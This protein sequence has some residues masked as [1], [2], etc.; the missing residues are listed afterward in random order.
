MISV[1]DM[2]NCCR[3]IELLHNGVDITQLD[4]LKQY[5]NPKTKKLQSRISEH[6][7]N[8]FIIK[9]EPAVCEFLDWVIGE[10]LIRD[11]TSFKSCFE[12]GLLSDESYINIV[13]D[14]KTFKEVMTILKRKNLTTFADIPQKDYDDEY[15]KMIE[16]QRK[17]FDY[18]NVDDA[19]PMIEALSNVNI[20]QNLEVLLALSKYPD[21]LGN[22]ILQAFDTVETDFEIKDFNKYKIIDK[23]LYIKI[24]QFVKDDITDKHYMKDFNYLV[25]SRNPYDYYFCSWGSSIQSCFSLNSTC[26]GWHGIVPMSTAK[27]SF[28][29]YGTSGV[30]NKISI[31]N[32]TKWPCPRILFR[33][34]GWLKPD[35][36]LL[37]DK[38]YIGIEFN[39][40]SSDVIDKLKQYVTNLFGYNYK[41][42]LNK[43]AYLLK[44]GEEYY[45]IQKEYNCNWYPD[46]VR[47]DIIEEQFCYRGIGYGLR[48]F[49]GKFPLDNN[50]TIQSEGQKITKISPTFTYTNR[51]CIIDGILSK[52]KICPITNLPILETESQSKY[53]KY[54]TKP[55]KEL[56][57][58]TY[59]DGCYKL[60]KATSMSNNYSIYVSEEGNQ[61]SYKDCNKFYLTP[62]MS[63][64]EKKINIKSFKEMITGCAKTS[65][66]ECV[67]VR[68]IEDDKVTF[69]KY[70]GKKDETSTTTV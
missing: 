29:V 67:L 59:L 52:T 39:N 21:E 28:L 1:E 34:W 44:Y 43:A 40:A 70:K 26:R 19:K 45:K 63:S 54:F 53:A 27:G 13:I 6:I 58:L 68:Y 14:L 46:S 60:D 51:Y 17:T 11:G 50:Y 66:Y 32:G 57:I 3:A 37:S 55:V 8:K 56:L 16:E 9:L 4:T 47:D 5:Y 22:K 69:V 48:C 61:L 7:P 35:G 15:V 12:R 38:W 10:Y 30:P 31:I 65:K 64:T 36:T 41:D 18:T 2:L 24:P 49:I 62:Q 23:R 33:F 25:I 20:R 42:L